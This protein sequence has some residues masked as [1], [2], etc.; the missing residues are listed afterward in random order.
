MRLL[1]PD[2][3]WLLLTI[4]ALI[5]IYLIKSPHEDRAV[6]STYIWKL[7]ERFMKKRLPVQRINK[8]LLFL[9]QLLMLIIAALMISRPALVS[10]ER[11]EYIVIIDASAS[12]LV[13]DEKGESRFERA[14]DEAQKLSKSIDSGHKFSIILASDN[15][16]YILQGAESR[17]EVK[18]ALKKAE[19]TYGGCDIA[20]A[21]D[22]AQQMCDLADKAE[23]TFITDSAHPE[24]KGI[25]I[26]DLRNNEWNVTVSSLEAYESGDNTVF[27]GTLTS[28][29]ID[30]TVTVGFRVDGKTMDAQQLECKANTETE[31]TFSVEELGYF[32][33]A[34]IFIDI[35]DGFAEDNSYTLCQRS[36]SNYAVLLLT[37][38]P[39]YLESVLKALTNCNLTVVNTLADYEAVRAEYGF[40][41]Y[42]Y[43]NIYPAE[44]PA[45]A[46]VIV[47]GTGLLPTGLAASSVIEDVTPLEM[48]GDS[49]SDVYLNLSLDDVVVARYSE[50]I[51]DTSWKTLLSLEN[52]PVLVTRELSNGMHQSVFSFDLHDSNL[53]LM[54]CFMVLMRNLVEYSV[55]AVLKDLDHSIGESITLHVLPYAEQLYVEDPDGNIEA[56]STENEYC[57]ITPTRTGI[58][59]AV[60]TTEKSG[61][62]VDF[63]VHIPAGEM[64][65][66]QMDALEV[67][68]PDEQSEKEKDDAIK[69]LWPWL[70]GAFLLLLLIEWGCY[71]REQY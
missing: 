20:D 50:L 30:A 63:F 64:E 1:N 27:N 53:P 57:T 9:L 35:E 42:I 14:I 17:N 12:M 51:G 56:L 16:A 34:E 41:L 3:L 59:T 22:L 44:Y 24:S 47:F 48:P 23:V 10:G 54:P 49:Q 33:T 45:S 29:V 31:I 8:F 36:N 7:S 40:D 61:E 69:E 37:E 43:D 55:P 11:C 5:I 52:L 71:Y 39:L 38:R 25:E 65:D 13:E 28:H 32:D 70:A 19:C 67:I 4:P 2:G 21:L 62:Y 6:S 15:P 26:I 68:L 58:Y 60:L 66:T 18:A 46:S